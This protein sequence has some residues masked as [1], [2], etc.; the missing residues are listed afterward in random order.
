MSN[1]IAELIKG[2]RTIHNFKPEPVPAKEM[3]VSAIDHAI[4]APNHRM[5]EPWQFHLI[6]SET[7]DR[8][9]RLNAELVRGKHG[10]KAAEGK[11]KRWS[12][13]PGWL[14]LTCER[15]DDQLREREDYAACC[16]VAQNLMLYLW[17]EGIGVKWT[18]GDV[19]RTEEFYQIVNADMTST[20]VVGLF[21]Y[22]YFDKLPPARRKPVAEVLFELA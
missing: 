21:W 11:L 3:I 16:C 5:T 6:G 7:K 14:L 17:N 12:E 10:D 20:S 9:C 22:G 15:S 18:T 8:I 2:R 13:I 1:V 19:I 4:W